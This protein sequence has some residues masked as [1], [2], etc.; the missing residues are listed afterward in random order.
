[1]RKFT[2]AGR[3]LVHPCYAIGPFG[4]PSCL[5]PPGFSIGDSPTLSTP[6]QSGGS[7]MVVVWY[8]PRPA[9]LCPLWFQMAAPSQSL[10]LTVLAVLTVLTGLMS[11]VAPMKPNH[12]SV[13]SERGRGQETPQARHRCKDRRTRK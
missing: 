6:W 13:G 10:V 11:I 7:R 2:L 5:Q 3:G 9:S 8:D 12:D 1:M 4:G